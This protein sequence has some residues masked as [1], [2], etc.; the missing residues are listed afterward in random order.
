MNYFIHHEDTKSTKDMIRTKHTYLFN[1]L[2]FV[3][4]VP[5]W[6]KTNLE[7]GVR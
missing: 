4:F 2:N 5:S 7:R 1:R 6:L 3:S